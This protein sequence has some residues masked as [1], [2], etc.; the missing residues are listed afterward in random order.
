MKKLEERQRYI[1]HQIK[2]CQRAIGRQQRNFQAD[3]KHNTIKHPKLGLDMVLLMSIPSTGNIKRRLR[4]WVKALKINTD[5]L[6][7]NSR[8]KIPPIK[9]EGNVYYFNN[10]NSENIVSR[11]E[12]DKLELYIDNKLIMST[13]L[14]YG[15]NFD[16]KG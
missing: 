16:Y 4:G 12:N 3:I 15:R 13:K 9:V 10:E 1:K 8:Q 6:K 7:Y 5:L 14:I 2:R 11:I